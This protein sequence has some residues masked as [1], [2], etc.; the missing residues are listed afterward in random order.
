VPM[1]VQ[2]LSLAPWTRDTVPGPGLLVRPLNAPHC[3]HL[4]TA[5]FLS[6]L[7]ILRDTV[8]F[9]QLA[10]RWEHSVDNGT[11]WAPCGTNARV[12]VQEEVA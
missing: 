12:T 5:W 11:N 6:E 10:A 4:V 9:K 2:V 7:G 3:V 1:P 8:S